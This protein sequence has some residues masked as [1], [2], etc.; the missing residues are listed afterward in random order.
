MGILKK[1]GTIKQ[2][3]KTFGKLV[4]EEVDDKR[5]QDELARR[6][7]QQGGGQR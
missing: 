5:A 1:V 4:K 2:A 3:K 6:R 7:Q